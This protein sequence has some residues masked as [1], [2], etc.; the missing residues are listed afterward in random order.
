M[1]GVT[2]VIT[3]R[4]LRQFLLQPDDETNQTFL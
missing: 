1:P 3:R 2:S 4:W